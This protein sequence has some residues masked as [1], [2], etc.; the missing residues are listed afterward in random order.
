MEADDLS[1]WAGD[2]V[3]PFCCAP[4]GMFGGGGLSF[5]RREV[6]LRVRVEVE[7]IRLVRINEVRRD[8][9]VIV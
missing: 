1:S 7:A 5:A 9:M 8:I 2:E 6:V 4:G 3:R